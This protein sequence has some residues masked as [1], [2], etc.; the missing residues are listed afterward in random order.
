MKLPGRDLPFA[1][2][3]TNPARKT[4]TLVA[5]VNGALLK[6]RAWPKTPP[7]DVKYAEAVFADK[8]SSA[9]DQRKISMLL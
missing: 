8:P 7:R 5:E 1:V 9:V 2:H 3:G 4:H 6:L